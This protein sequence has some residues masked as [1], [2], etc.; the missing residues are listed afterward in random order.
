MKKNILFIIESSETGGAEN[1][2]AELI[3]RIDRTQYTPHVALLYEGWL[4]DTLVAAGVTPHL[5]STRKGGFDFRHY[6]VLENSLSVA[7]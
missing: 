6:W 1:V 5:V 2:F 7:A 4:F 3:K